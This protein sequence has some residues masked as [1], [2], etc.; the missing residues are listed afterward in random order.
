MTI[1]IAWPLFT[2]RYKICAESDWLDPSRI[3]TYEMQFKIQAKTKRFLTVLKDC[4]VSL[5]GS[6]KN[7]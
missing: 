1:N 4:M 6:V 7:S 3:L 5:N 2:Q